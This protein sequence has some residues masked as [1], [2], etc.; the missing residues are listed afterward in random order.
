MRTQARSRAVMSLETSLPLCKPLTL[1]AGKPL[2]LPR[3]MSLDPVTMFPHKGRLTNSVLSMVT[4]KVV[5]LM[6]NKGKGG[7]LGLGHSSQFRCP[8]TAVNLD[9]LAA[10]RVPQVDIRYCYL[11]MHNYGTQILIWVL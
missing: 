1:R 2:Q 4:I 11:P 10:L 8:Y 9:S 7:R 3:M 5:D 6:D